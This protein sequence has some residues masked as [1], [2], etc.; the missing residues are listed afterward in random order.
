MSRKGENI[1]RRKDGRWEGRYVSSR[2]KDG[3]VKYGYVYGKTYAEAKEKKLA[4]IIQ[5]PKKSQGR[6]SWATFSVLSASWLSEGRGRW[7]E[8]TFQKYKEHLNIHLLPKFGDRTLYSISSE[9]LS[10]FLS[11][12]STEGGSGLSPSTR[13][14]FLTIMK[15]IKD[16]AARSGISAGY[17]PV[18]VRIDGRKSHKETRTFTL[19]EQ[20]RLVKLISASPD[21]YGKGV[22]LSLFT[23]LR[24]GE[25]CALRWEDV[26]LEKKKLYVKR[27]VQRIKV[28]DDSGKKTALVVDR[29][30]SASSI[31]T[32]PILEDLAEALKQEIKPGCYII[33]GLERDPADPRTMEKHFKRFLKICGVEDAD[34]HTTRRTFA[35]RCVEKGMDVK[36]LSE[37]L[38]HSDISTTLRYYVH[39]SMSHKEESIKLLTDLFTV[40]DRRQI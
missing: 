26:N 35:T 9:E 15:Q 30:K 3:R 32:I 37:L 34:F 1:Y 22:L 28:E 17:D 20:E 25:L 18:L 2:A 27:T 13:G 14:V 33:S 8:S 31:R 36:T 40:K 6:K 4:A 10:S 24:L 5:L 12:H 38:G 21:P 29:P 23:G 39:P 11:L 16:H 19:E 7:K